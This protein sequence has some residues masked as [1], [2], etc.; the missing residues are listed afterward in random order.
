MVIARGRELGTM[1]NIFEPVFDQRLDVPGFVARRA[2]VA[3]QLGCERIG[4]SVW[5]VPPGQAAYPYH[6]HLGEE[7]LLVVLSGSPSL[8]TPDGWRELVAGEAVRFGTGEAGAHQVA[9][10]SDEVVRFLAFSTSGTPEILVYP[11]SSKIGAF[12]R[13]PTGSGLFEL[14]RAVDSVPYYEGETPPTRA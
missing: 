9:N 1:A 6:Y 2:R 10:F 11:D 13:L 7:E 3:M 12:E 4:A 5:E 8:R 14:F